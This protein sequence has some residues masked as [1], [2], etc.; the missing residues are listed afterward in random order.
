LHQASQDTRPIRAE[1]VSGQYLNL[2]PYTAALDAA[3]T[4]LIDQ[5]IVARY[6]TGQVQL[7]LFNLDHI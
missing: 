2:I 1:W 6:T 5:F 4:G 7:K 3:L